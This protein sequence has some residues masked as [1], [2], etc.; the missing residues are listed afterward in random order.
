MRLFTFTTHIFRQMFEGTESQ[1]PMIWP[2][3][4][5]ISAQKCGFIETVQP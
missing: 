2:N 3:E 4:S 1:L 5:T